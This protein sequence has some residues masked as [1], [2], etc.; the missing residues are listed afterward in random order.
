MFQILFIPALDGEFET[1]KAVFDGKADIGLVSSGVIEF[2]QNHFSDMPNPPIFT[3]DPI[4]DIKV[5]TVAS[6]FS[7]LS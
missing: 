1:V 3:H 2:Y 4:E 6:N 5:N 7:L